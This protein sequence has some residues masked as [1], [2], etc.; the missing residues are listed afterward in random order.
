[1]RT[2]VVSVRPIYL[3]AFSWMFSIACGAD[4]C[5]LTVVGVECGSIVSLR[6]EYAGVQS[7]LLFYRLLLGDSNRSTPDV[8]LLPRGAGLHSSFGFQTCFP[9]GQPVVHDGM[10]EAWLDVDGH[11]VSRCTDPDTPEAC[12]P[13]DDDP[14]A[15]ESFVISSMDV[16]DVLLVVED[17]TGEQATQSDPG[18]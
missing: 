3:L 6:V 11:D 13:D 12:G 2:C 17:P 18:A 16:T 5:P 10:A 1:M 14:Q 15:S 9:P 4:D 7:G 8:A